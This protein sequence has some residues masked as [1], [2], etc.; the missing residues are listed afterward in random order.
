MTHRALVFLWLIS[1]SI[2]LS[3]SIHIVAKGRISFFKNLWVIFH[4]V[5][6]CV[7]VYIYI[8]GMSAKSL[9]SW[10]TLCDPVNCCPPGS[11]AH[12]ILQARTLEWGAMPSSRASSWPGVW[13]CI[14]YVS[15]SGRQVLYHLCHLGSPYILAHL[16]YSTQ[17]M[18]VWSL[19]RE[20]LLP[21]PG[22][23]NGNPVLCPCLGNTM[24]RASWQVTICGAPKELGVT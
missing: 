24:D 22:E 7:C 14:S 20:G 11:S 21:S 8:Y 3:R 1:T 17:E 4:C 9:H 13:T 6:V 15:F 23:G 10:P 19:R 16:L 2:I 5:C 18:G 12:G